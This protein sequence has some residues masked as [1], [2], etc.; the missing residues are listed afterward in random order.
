MPWCGEAPGECGITIQIAA[1]AG[2]RHDGPRAQGA[3][4]TLSVGRD[5]RKGATRLVACVL[6]TGRQ[7]GRDG[8]ELGLPTYLSPSRL[9]SLHFPGQSRNHALAR[10]AKGGMGMGNGESGKQGNVTAEACDAMGRRQL[11]DLASQAPSAGFWQLRP[12]L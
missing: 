3:A 5:E 4:A 2:E 6:G 12:R 9:D 1:F 11:R 7:K 10:Q 8:R